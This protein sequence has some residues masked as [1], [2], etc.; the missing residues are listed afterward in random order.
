MMDLYMVGM[1]LCHIPTLHHYD[2]FPPGEYD[3]WEYAN[4]DDEDNQAEVSVALAV[5]QGR[6][7]L[8]FRI[9]SGKANQCNGDPA[10]TNKT[11]TQISSRKVFKH[12][13]YCIL[14]IVIGTTLFVIIV[15]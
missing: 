6:F 7:Q 2:I 12:F 14:Y 10:K 11:Q 4:V 9:L 15:F 1:W 3:W 8:K 13:V 5:T